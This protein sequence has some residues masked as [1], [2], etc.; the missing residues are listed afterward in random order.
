MAAYHPF[1]TPLTED[2]FFIS[3]YDARQRHDELLVMESSWGNTR[4]D[5]S[6]HVQFTWFRRNI[7]GLESAGFEMPK[8]QLTHCAYFSQGYPVFITYEPGQGQQRTTYLN[9]SKKCLSRPIP[10]FLTCKGGSAGRK[11]TRRA[12]VDRIRAE[13]ASMRTTDDLERITP[14]IWTELTT[15]GRKFF[16]RCGMFIMND[17]DK[18]AQIF[19]HPGRGVPGRTSYGF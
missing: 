6:I 4:R 15:H 1:R 13:I 9:V 5:L 12:S 17:S 3:I 2:P 18:K 19:L 16:F 7:Y 8:Q 10:V 11:P 14:L